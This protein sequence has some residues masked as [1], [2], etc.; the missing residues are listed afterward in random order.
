MDPG[1]DRVTVAFSL[2]ALEHLQDPG[3]VFQQTRGWARSVGVVS[4][5]PMHAQ[6]GFARQHGI[7]YG[8][9]SGP[10]N[11]LESL[12][13]IKGRPEQDAERYLLIGAD[14]EQEAVAST[15]W[16]YLSIEEAAAAAEWSLSDTPAEDDSRGWP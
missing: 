4:D 12:P 11:L 5:R 15:G 13:V 8:F 6:T 14:V 16:E 7:D 10:R 3:G 1:A 9:H 2:A